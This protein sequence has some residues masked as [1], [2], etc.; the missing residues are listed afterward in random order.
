MDKHSPS[1][2]PLSP[3]TNHRFT[4]R[5]ARKAILSASVVPLGLVLV[6]L[7]GASA[8]ADS[9]FSPGDQILGGRD[10]TGT[11]SFQIGVVGTTGNTNNWP[12]AE[13]PNLAID[14]TAGKYLNFAQTF[15]GFLVHPNFNGGNGSVA[16]SMKLWT[17]NDAVE[18]DPSSYLILGSNDTL[19]F[20]ATTFD[21]SGFTQVATGSLALPS[22]R[23]N[24]GTLLD[25]NSQTVSFSNLNGYKNY[26]VVF[27]TIKN[28]PGTAN[29]MQ[30]GEIELLAVPEPGSLAVLG[31]GALGL[32]ARRRRA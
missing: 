10:D 12:A 22:G 1:R 16:T 26:L 15:T 6:S 24:T 13:T 21:L 27:P 28:A 4:A 32:L 20:G 18:R 8:L 30:I 17:A 31:I 11:N 29:S 7:P 19:D 5:L 3:L 9:I 2:V 23:N 25:A 14:G